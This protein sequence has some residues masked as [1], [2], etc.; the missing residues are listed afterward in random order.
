MAL[1]NYGKYSFASHIEYECVIRAVHVFI[2]HRLYIEA[3]SFVR[4]RMGK[5]LDDKFVVFDNIMKAQ[6]CLSCASVYNSIGFRR[7]HAFFLR[8]SVLFRLNVADDETRTGAK[9][10][11]LIYPILYKSLRGYG[12]GVNDE[13][14]ETSSSSLKLML[15]P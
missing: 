13:F 12:I 15:L 4:D 3:E 8:L 7:K 6:I 2:Y 11:Q 9:D 10:Y 5:F 1:E 14:N